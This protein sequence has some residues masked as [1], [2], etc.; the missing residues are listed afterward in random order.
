MVYV[1]GWN[2][3]HCPV[4]LLFEIAFAFTLILQ[5]NYIPVTLI[6]GGIIYKAE[7]SPPICCCFV[8][9]QLV[10]NLGD[11]LVITESI[12]LACIHFIPLERQLSYFGARPLYFAHLPGVGDK[13]ATSV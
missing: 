13:T 9:E 11:K 5:L 8:M 12:Q 2:S 6:K 4:N 1:A 10:I 3:T 7:F